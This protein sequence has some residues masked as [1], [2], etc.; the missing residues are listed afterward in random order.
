MALCPTPDP[1]IT[2]ASGNLWSRSVHDQ[3]DICHTGS[4]DRRSSPGS[5]PTARRPDGG[6]R[7]TARGRT[8]PSSERPRTRLACTPRF[9]ARRRRVGGQGC[10]ATRQRLL[11][12]SG[13]SSRRR[14]AFGLPRRHRRSPGPSLGRTRRA[15]ANR[16]P[17]ARRWGRPP[18][19]AHT[20]RPDHR[21]PASPRSRPRLTRPRRGT[22]A[23]TAP[24]PGD[25]TPSAHRWC[26]GSR[27]Q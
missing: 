15:L 5:E 21:A 23:G 19:R 22:V 20:H 25:S 26:H 11:D 9:T 4:C 1:P 12:P 14:P 10:R 2:F 17:D 18:G 7:R 3:L 6:D 16:R 27:V 13:R 8:E 24:P